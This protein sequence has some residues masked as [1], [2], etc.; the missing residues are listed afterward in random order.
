[1]GKTIRK[2]EAK[3]VRNFE[4]A[5]FAASGKRGGPMKDR[6]DKRADQKE[7]KFLRDW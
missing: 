3:K 7:R 1:M 2:F 4:A 6:R 5:N